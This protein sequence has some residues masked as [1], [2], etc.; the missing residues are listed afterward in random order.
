M[1]EAAPAPHPRRGASAVTAALALTAA[2]L[3][4]ALVPG[5]AHP[6]RLGH[7]AGFTYGY[8]PSVVAHG[9]LDFTDDAEPFDSVMPHT[10]EG[11]THNAF[12]V[13]PAVWWSVPFLAAHATGA[14]VRTATGNDSPAPDGRSWPY[15]GL[16]GLGALLVGV[17]GIWATYAAA[18]RLASPAGAL[19]GTAAVWLAG[20]AI[21][22]THV[23]TMGSHAAGF[24]SAAL[25][26]LVWLRLRDR[27]DASLWRVAALGLVAGLVVLCRWQNA[28]VLVGPAIDVARGRITGR[29]R[30]DVAAAAAFGG[31][32]LVALLPQLVVWDV[33]Y[34][35]P[36]RPPRGETAG[37]FL[38]LGRLHV[39]DVLFSW[40]HG[41][42]SWHPALAAGVVGLAVATRRHPLVALSLLASLAA[43]TIV[44]AGVLD[45]WAGASFGARRFDGLWPALAVGAAVLADRVPR[46]LAA[47][48]VAVL[49][50][51]NWVLLLAFQ[52]G[53]VSRIEAVT[54]SDLLDAAGRVS[55]LG[56]LASWSPRKVVWV[57]GLAAA[58][59]AATSTAA[60]ARA[61]RARRSLS[62]SPGPAGTTRRRTAGT[63]GAVAGGLAAAVLVAGTLAAAGI[64]EPGRFDVNVFEAGYFVPQ[65]DEPDRT[66]RVV[67][68][69]DD[70][71][72]LIWSFPGFLPPGRYQAR[73][74]SVRA[75][76]RG[77]PARL[78]VRV[79][80]RAVVT[81]DV[82]PAA[83]DVAG[84]VFELEEGFRRLE[85][86]VTGG[87]VRL[88]A[89][90]VEPVSGAASR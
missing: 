69:G 90:V 9:D 59:L 2:A 11:R 52:E 87:A 89:V 33:L 58:G 65:P 66:D 18:R 12:P 68:P 23:Y 44:N 17:V 41:M 21:A 19:T 45:W 48:V 22:Y 10:V 24:A 63:A 71:W 38:D 50:A 40:R 53:L 75:E 84:G 43:A 74:T 6:V 61:A 47:A 73:A 16:V 82:G 15:D 57:L 49:A 37:A 56:E 31:A 60:A 67:Q 7:D 27:P 1:T 62:T 79:D 36:L 39:I 51:V 72:T 5:D 30:P 86:V 14:A 76:G 46:A 20:P 70:V 29:D 64:A 78:E 4:A 85:L 26:L 54:P 28:V 3:V 8:L 80:G 77:A 81:A 34:G 25:L 13:G 83:A 35:S 32:A 88:D 42:L 55:L